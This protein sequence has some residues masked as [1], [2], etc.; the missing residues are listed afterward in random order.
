MSEPLQ[1]WL[2]GGCFAGLIVI[3]LWIYNHSRK[4]H[5][6]RETQQQAELDRLSDEIGHAGKPGTILG[7]QHLTLKSLREVR[8]TLGMPPDPK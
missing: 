5:G 7:R 4:C 2:F 8:T 1:M 6:T 3:F